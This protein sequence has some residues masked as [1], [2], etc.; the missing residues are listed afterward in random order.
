MPWMMSFPTPKIGVR[1][2]RS[3][4]LLLLLLCAAS[5]VGYWGVASISG[6]T[7]RT[8]RE[9]GHISEHAARARAEMLLL[10][11]YEKDVFLNVADPAVAASYYGKWSEAKVRIEQRVADLERYATGKE[12]TVTV[13]TIKDNLA[14]YAAGFEGVYERI[15]DGTLRSPAACNAAFEGSKA[16]AARAEDAAREFASSGHERMAATESEVVAKTRATGVVLVI[17]SILVIA[18]IRR[19]MSA[20]RAVARSVR[21]C[22]ILYRC[23]EAMVRGADEGRLVADICR[24]LVEE[25]GYRLAWVGFAEGGTDGTVRP[26]GWLGRGETAADGPVAAW[27]GCGTGHGLAEAAIRAGEPVVV[28][29]LRGERARGRW[30]PESVAM[31]FASATALPL[32]CE[33]GRPFGALTLYAGERAAVDGGEIELLTRLAKDLGYGI[34]AIRAFER[35]KHL[36]RE[37]SSSREA[38]RDLAREIQSAREEERARIAREIHDELGQQ[39]T[40]MKMEVAWLEKRL[41]GEPAP[42]REKA[43]S[44]KGAIDAAIGTVRRIS[45]ELRPGVLDHLGIGAAVAWQ[46]GSFGS[47]TGI[48]CTVSVPDR[49]FPLGKDRETALFRIFQEALTN[50][51]RHSGADSVDV[52][53]S[54]AGGEVVLTVTDNGKGICG[55]GAARPGSLGLIGMRERVLPFGGAVEIEG[56]AGSGTRLKVRLPIDEKETAA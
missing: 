16:P 49:V 18:D 54:E 32:F 22:S 41:P 37:L 31:R 33:R 24:I 15:T 12:D 29:D 36:N 55:E 53:L 20:G 56:S 23:N 17:V 47:R 40:V 9:D 4:V 46:A 25:G 38:L 21:A 10:R 30:M 7:I 44:I 39:L 19:K 2:D 50:V 3:F 48:A 51:A 45:S 26:V 42:L 34:C 14:L 52:D 13:G 5:G 8:L 6:A 35:Q 11:R 43:G 1:L 28:A 27:A